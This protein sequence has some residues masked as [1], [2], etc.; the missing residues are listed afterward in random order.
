MIW[1]ESD[2]GVIERD[3]S[4]N[5]M[6]SGCIDGPFGSEKRRETSSTAA[7]DMIVLCVM[8]KVEARIDRMKTLIQFGTWSRGE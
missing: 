1:W 2:S 7:D 6:S 3:R 5:C 4:C 8:N